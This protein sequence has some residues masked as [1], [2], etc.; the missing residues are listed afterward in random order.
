MKQA[1]ALSCGQMHI[2]SEEQ[3]GWY[4]R[5]QISL[6]DLMGEFE[7]RQVGSSDK[8]KHGKETGSEG[9][10]GERLSDGGS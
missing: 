7:A 2:V 6:D 9:I 8:I 10:T 4:C 3:H 1:W 5:S